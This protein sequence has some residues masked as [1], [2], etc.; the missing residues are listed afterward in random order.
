MELERPPLDE[1]ERRPVAR[2]D[3]VAGPLL[4]G[5]VEPSVV[6]YGQSLD[7]VWPLLAETES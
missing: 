5:P 7:C 1:P 2:G 3:Y 4:S 6:P